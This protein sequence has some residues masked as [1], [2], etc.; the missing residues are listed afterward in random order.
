MGESDHASMPVLSAKLG[1]RVT[2]APKHGGTQAWPQ[3][4]NRAS[5]QP[6]PTTTAPPGDAGLHPTSPRSHQAPQ[7]QH[8]A[9][10]GGWT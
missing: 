8:A 1:R 10:E 2:T 4:W 3:A 5:V 6:P 9:R 7:G